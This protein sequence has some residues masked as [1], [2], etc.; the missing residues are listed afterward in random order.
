[1]KRD[2]PDRY[3]FKREIRNETHSLR[4]RLGTILLHWG[5]SASPASRLRIMAPCAYPVLFLHGEDFLRTLAEGGT[6]TAGFPPWGTHGSGGGLSPRSICRAAHRRPGMISAHPS[7][8]RSVWDPGTRRHMLG[9]ERSEA[10]LPDTK[11]G[12]IA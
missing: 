2:K 9:P 5:C 11:A 1:M 12:R 8:R 10:V 4:K 3:S 6:G 7:F